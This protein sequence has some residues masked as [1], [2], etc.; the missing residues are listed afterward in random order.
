MQEHVIRE[1]METTMTQIRELV[2]VETVVG[3]PIYAQDGIVIFPVSKVAFGF[4]SGGTDYPGKSPKEAFGGGGGAGITITPMAFV[5]INDGDV[6]IL[7][8]STSE[9][10]ADRIVN[11]VPEM[12]D[13][14]KDLFSKKKKEKA[15]DPDSA[16][17]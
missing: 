10:T 3:D 6:K 12:F 2:G 16:A 9:N 8:I 13:K 11:L 1:L 4:G 5:V 15:E 7:N 17:Q 14:V